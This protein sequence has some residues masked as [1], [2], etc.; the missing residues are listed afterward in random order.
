[1]PKDCFTEKT[2][3]W[4]WVIMI[5]FIVAIVCA[6]VTS[7]GQEPAYS[8]M[9]QPLPRGAQFR[10]IALT[11]CPYCPGLLDAQ[12]RCNV[13]E[14][15][16]YSPNWGK[17]P[18]SRGIPVRQVLIREL[19]LEVA[20]SQGKTSV[21]IHSVYIGG[22]AEKAGLQA[23]DRICRFNGRKVTSVKQFKAIVARAKPE[24]DIKIQVR[25]GR[26]KMKSVVMIGE[27]EMEGVT[28]PKTRG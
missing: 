16:V 20:P 9:L 10:N 21:I 7:S 13:R 6:I 28:L 8:S 12:G 23:G 2:K 4:F 1:M 26:T 18:S 5:V 25:R 24:S 15:P 19:A 14:C 22:N 27:G 3:N 17:P 11:R